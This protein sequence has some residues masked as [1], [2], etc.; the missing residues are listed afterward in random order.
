MPLALTV[1]LLTIVV[2]PS[3]QS[4]VGK[5][6]PEQNP[7]RAEVVYHIWDQDIWAFS[8]DGYGVYWYETY[9]DLVFSHGDEYPIEEIYSQEF[10]DLE[11][12][13]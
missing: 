5:M 8:T 12:V 1:R 11:R 7:L 2:S 6:P 9:A 13:W 10:D 3:T 4:E